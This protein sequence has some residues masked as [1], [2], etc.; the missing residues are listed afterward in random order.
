MPVLDVRNL[1]AKTLAQLAEAYDA[2]CARELQALAKLDADPARAGI[3]DA[4]SLAL[5]LPDM[6]TLR[7]LLSREPGL[8]GKAP[9]KPGK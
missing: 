1:P 4:L 3:D 8:T 7:Q 6:K 5:G 2:L 9:A